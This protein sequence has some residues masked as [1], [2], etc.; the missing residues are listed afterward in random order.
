[1]PSSRSPTQPSNVIT[2]RLRVLA[3]LG[4]TSSTVLI[5]DK[6]LKRKSVAF[7]RHARSFEGTGLEIGGPSKVFSADGYWPAYACAER[8]DNVNFRDTTEWHGTMRDGKTFLFSSH[9]APGS[10]FI[11][12]AGDLRGIEDRSYDFL[13]SSHML[14]HTANP[15]GA[16][17]EWFN[18]CYRIGMEPSTTGAP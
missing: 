3:S 14:E 12:E 7:A 9:K 15:I 6:V 18:S 8:V 17:R 11:R 13:L 5:L 2:R 10:Q 1:M 4:V 16:L